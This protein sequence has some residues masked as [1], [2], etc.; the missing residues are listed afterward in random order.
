MAEFEEAFS[1]KIESI[2]LL[3]MIG[4]A[5]I[6]LYHIGTFNS[7]IE[8]P[9]AGVSLFFCISGF[10]MMYTTQKG[11]TKNFLVN[12]LI[13]IVPL[14]WLMTGATFAAMWLI[15]SVFSGG[16]SITELI[17]SLFF[18][19]YA[20]GGLKTA[21]VVRPIVGPG[22]TL[23]YDLWFTVIFALCMRISERLKGLLVVAVC[24][25]MLPLQWK[26]P[27]ERPFL[28]MISM[29]WWLSFATGVLSFYLLKWLW[30]KKVPVYIRFIIGIVGLIA[31]Y[32][33]FCLRLDM[34]RNAFLSLIVLT[35]T[36]VLFRKA[37]MPHTINLLGNVSFSFYLIHYYVVMVFGKI[38]DWKVISLKTCTGIVLAFLCSIW[39]AYVSYRLVEQMLCNWLKK[40]TSLMQLI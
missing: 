14:Y 19:P 11:G 27:M 2:S 16:A 20:R 3:R 6:A 22:W 30:N 23:F 31:L 18:I 10:L 38:F 12:R 28:Y 17:D 40:K 33:M 24:T 36:V 29:P 8:T 5:G 35:C 32:L 34:I 13:R 15:P 9:Q 7:Y 39:L 4:A 37:K 25:A 1:G 26:F 21:V